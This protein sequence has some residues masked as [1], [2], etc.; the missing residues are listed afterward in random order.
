MKVRSCR[1]Q[2]SPN[3]LLLA[4][5]W[6]TI[7]PSPAL[8]QENP[9]DSY[10]LQPKQN[11][12]GYRFRGD[13]CEGQYIEQVASTALSIASLTRGFEEYDLNS[14]K[15]L[16]IKWPK[17]GEHDIRLRAHGIK[18]KLYYRMDT[19]RSAETK[20]YQWPI[21]ILSALNILKR[22][23]GIVGWTQKGFGDKTQKVYLPLQIRQNQS[24]EET[25]AYRLVL[26]PGVQLKEVYVSLASVDEEGMS[27]KNLQE[28]K[29]LGYG[30]YPAQRA[31]P[32]SLRGFQES[33]IYNVTISAT[34]QNGTDTAI[35]L[36]VYHSES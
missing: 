5:V 19:T 4:F 7:L 33:G 13:R 16:Q 6:L 20:T 31:I 32:I 11:P 22:S 10:L 8:S 2:L 15:P 14:D 30:Y 12:L 1:V 9:C 26:W 36:L 24:L 27:K 29:P 21:G 34:L 23:I 3:I 17:L 35:R 25:G 18:W 28:G